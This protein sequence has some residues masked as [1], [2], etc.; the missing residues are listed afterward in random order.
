MGLLGLR[1]VVLFAFMYSMSH[2]VLAGCTALF[3]S[4]AM[5]AATIDRVAIEGEIHS[6]L[7]RAAA[8]LKI[9]G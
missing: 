7:E 8:L 3:A 9:Q 4:G 2:G 6:R 5:G 1:W